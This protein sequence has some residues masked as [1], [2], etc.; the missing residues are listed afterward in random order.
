[1]SARDAVIAEAMTWLRTPYHN[2]ARIKGAGVDCL[3][4]LAA[5]YEAVGLIEHVDPQYSPDWHLHHTAELYVDGVLQFADEFEGE[6][7]LPGDVVIWR[8]GRTFSHGAIVV[9][10]PLIIHAYRGLA[11][12]LAEASDGRLRGRPMRSFRVRGIDDGR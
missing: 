12:E 5:V 4:L 9:Q 6:D 7:P 1:M 10:W 2:N 11:V 3:Q 8:F